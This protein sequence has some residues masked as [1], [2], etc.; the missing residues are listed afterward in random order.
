MKRS[1][2]VLAS[3]VIII[4]III[5]NIDNTNVKYSTSKYVELL[6]CAEGI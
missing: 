4:I 2:V 1:T 3:T 5:G 6:T